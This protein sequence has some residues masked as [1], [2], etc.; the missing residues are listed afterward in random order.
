MPPDHLPAVAA[1]TVTL[2]L[3]VASVPASP[4]LRATA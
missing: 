2:A 3:G 4:L 1:A